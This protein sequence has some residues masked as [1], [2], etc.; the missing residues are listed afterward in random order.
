[1]KN[2]IL[3]LK[4]IVSE[5]LRQDRHA[6]FDDRFV[7]GGLF[8]E[9]FDGLEEYQKKAYY[10]M[11]L[12]DFHAKLQTNELEWANEKDQIRY[13]KRLIQW[14]KTL[15]PSEF[16]LLKPAAQK[17]YISQLHMF[18]EPA[19]P[20]YYDMADD[21]VKKLYLTKWRKKPEL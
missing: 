13:I 11:R 4:L 16:T 12:K 21:K 20:M 19:L 17:F 5:S 8:P 10:N 7:N 3:R 1:M 15:N 14:G 18:G 6:T 9:E 2:L